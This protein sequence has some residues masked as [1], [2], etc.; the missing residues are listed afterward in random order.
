MIVKNQPNLTPQLTFRLSI[1]I[2]FW[3]TFAMDIQLYTRKK[4][5][6][7]YLGENESQCTDQ[8]CDNENVHQRLK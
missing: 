7:K 3:T 4:L 6:K 8:Q 2:P 5:V 1:G